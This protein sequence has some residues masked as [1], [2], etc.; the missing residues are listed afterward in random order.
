MKLPKIQRETLAAD[1][2]AGLVGAIAAIPDAMAGAVLA[3]VNPIFG[4]YALM[5]GTPV[6]ALTTGSVFM[7]VSITG[8]MAL[9]VGSALAAFSG[10][11]QVQ[12]LIVLTILIGVFQ[13]ALGLLKQGTLTRF[14]SNAVMTG[15]LTGIA[16]LIILGQLGDF[17]GYHSE[18]SNKVRQ[19]VDLLLH[20]KQTDL[21]TLAIGALTLALI[22][23]LSRTRLK[24]LAMMIA[25]LIGTAAVY[26]LSWDSVAVVGDIGQIPRGLPTPVLPDLS[27]VPELL[28][29]AVAIGVIGLVQGAGVGRSVPNPDK[30]LPDPSRDFGGQGLANIATGFFQGM[31]V[32]GSLSA[33]ALNVSTGARTRLANVFLGLIVVVLVL[34]AGGLVERVAMPCMAAILI[35][36]G[37]ETIKFE[38][39]ADVWDIGM[40][41]RVVMI[42]TF[43]ATL[44]LPI[45]QAVG[46]GVILSLAHFLYSAAM[47]V[48]VVE[49]EPQEDGTFLEQPA[50]AELR[51]NAVTLLDVYGNVYFAAAYTLEGILP[52]AS[53]SRRSVVV[54]RLRGDE[55]VGSTFISV[56]ERYTER[57]VEGGG[58]LMLAGVSTR[59]MRR[60]ERTETTEMIPAEDIF[61]AEDTVG[62]STHKALAAGQAWLAH[63]QSA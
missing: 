42:I 5:V 50:P 63:G 31:P 57:L 19:G 17:T 41:S 13:L 27:L 21:Q 37:W 43:V 26:L 22:V 54:L 24:N 18:Y 28:S 25:L 32:G 38:E 4:L 46:L 30:S 51:S 35:Y 58:K 44:V 60:L 7:N 45:H 6:G 39:I 20:P 33:T 10:D 23:I 49:M 3:G 48:R 55:D 15:F 1:F 2:V 59:A 36:A 8:A 40:A 14:V 9:A 11:A 29:S 61:L 34:L 56:I 62:A 12:A 52:S 53:K 47:S 16:V